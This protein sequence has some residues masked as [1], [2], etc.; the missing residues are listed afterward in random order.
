MVAMNEDAIQLL[1]QLLAM[2][3]ID[4]GVPLPIVAL[5]ETCVKSVNA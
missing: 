2:H 5:V 3:Y 4:G 1:R